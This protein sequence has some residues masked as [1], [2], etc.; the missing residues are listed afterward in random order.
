LR[1]RG[2]GM[3]EKRKRGGRVFLVEDFRRLDYRTASRMP[4]PPRGDGDAGAFPW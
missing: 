2:E 4:G 1:F 3:P